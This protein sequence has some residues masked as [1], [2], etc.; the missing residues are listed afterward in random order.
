MYFISGNYL[1]TFSVSLIG[2][3]TFELIESNFDDILIRLSFTNSTLE[4][5]FLNKPV[6]P[7]KIETVIAIHAVTRL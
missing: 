2:L 7:I 5:S 6:I 3:I 1:I 4:L